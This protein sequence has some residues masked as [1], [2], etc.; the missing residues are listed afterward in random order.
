MTLAA[1]RAGAIAE[2]LAAA[3]VARRPLARI[4]T[5]AD[6][7]LADGYAVQRALME[8]AG[9]LRGFKVGTT[10]AA[11]MARVGIDEP[12]LGYIEQ[13]DAVP[14]G[15]VVDLGEL[16]AP[17]IE[18]ELALVTARDLDAAGCEADEALA[19]TAYAVPAFEILD[20]R[21]LAGPFDVVAAVADN[22]STARH[23]LGEERLD[24]RAV[25]LAAVGAV[26]HKNGVEIARGT[27]AAVLG[28]PARS[29]A[30]L[31]R[32]LAREGI[33]VPAGSVVLTGGFSDAVPAAAG[34]A[35]VAR[36]TP[37]GT[38][39]CTFSAPPTEGPS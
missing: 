13:G 2:R 3:R 22:M 20:S 15:G 18:M 33:A 38:V 19:A 37:G 23:V 21:Y 31:V 35:F 10:S 4:L 6:G 1:G 7:S 16:I 12:L 26:M 39:A 27:G 8:R 24:P 11:A 17:R 34:D 9:A 14:N 5:R 30:W 29:L 32:T 36:F 28:H 25:D